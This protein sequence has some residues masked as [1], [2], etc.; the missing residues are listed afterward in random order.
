MLAMSEQKKPKRS[1][2]SLGVYIASEL[3]DAFD[4]FIDQTEPR[5][6]KTAVIEMLLTRYLTEQEFWPPPTPDQPVAPKPA[7]RTRK[8]S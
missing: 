8:K 3:R 4:R 6:S 7:G 5:T 2:V 1:G